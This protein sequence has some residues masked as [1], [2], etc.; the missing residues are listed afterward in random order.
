MAENVAQP[1]E[2]S[3]KKL[4]KHEKPNYLLPEYGSSD[5]CCVCDC[6][7]PYSK[8]KEA[9][10]KRW[11]DAPEFAKKCCCGCKACYQ[12]PCCFL[13]CCYETEACEC[14]CPRCLLCPC[15]YFACCQTCP[16]CLAC[17]WCLKETKDDLCHGGCLEFIINCPFNTCILCFECCE[18][19]CCYLTDSELSANEK[20]NQL[21]DINEPNQQNE[22]GILDEPN[23]Q[24]QNLEDESVSS[25]DEA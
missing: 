5:H 20:P 18:C 3:E 12:S 15:C 9:L 8:Y 16:K 7:C 22:Q 4:K 11:D 13:C 23:K 17:G 19:A 14:L 24:G 6:T 10:V 25:K 1:V 2:K 21:E